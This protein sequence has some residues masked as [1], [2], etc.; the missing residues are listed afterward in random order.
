MS[1]V[2]PPWAP[3]LSGRVPGVVWRGGSGGPDGLQE[4]SAWLTGPSAT[5]PD[6]VLTPE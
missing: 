1:P 3:R 4:L 2:A 5:P 6:W